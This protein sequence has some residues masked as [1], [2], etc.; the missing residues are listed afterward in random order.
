MCQDNVNPH[1]FNVKQDA[2]LIAL[3]GMHHVAPSL[4]IYAPIIDFDW[5]VFVRDNQNN[6]S[7]LGEGRI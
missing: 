5:A 6:K 7:L 4:V 2:P 3:H 1:R